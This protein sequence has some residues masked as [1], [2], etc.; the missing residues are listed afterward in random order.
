MKHDQLTSAL[1]AEPFRPFRAH[2]GSGKFV[3][4]RNPGL[5]VVSDTGRVAVAFRPGSDG[6]DV[7]NLNLVERLEIIESNGGHKGRRN[8]KRKSA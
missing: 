2:F 6:W 8:G 7:L 4:I 3:E 1:D 5:V